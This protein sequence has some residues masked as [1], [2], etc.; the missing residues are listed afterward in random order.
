MHIDNPSWR[1]A[2]LIGALS[3]LVD[4]G[5]DIVDLREKLGRRF[6]AVEVRSAEQAK[7]RRLAHEQLDA[8]AALLGGVAAQARQGVAPSALEVRLEATRAEIERFTTKWLS[9]FPEGEPA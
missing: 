5:G 9:A 7:M 1:S 6:T 3:R 2:A 4:Q 8:L